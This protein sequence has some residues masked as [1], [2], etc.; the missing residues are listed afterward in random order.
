VAGTP[1][2]LTI[3][4]ALVDNVVEGYPSGSYA[5][6]GAGNAGGGAS[7]SNPTAND[8]MLV[9]AEVVMEVPVVWVVTDGFIRFKWRSWWYA[10]SNLW[11]D[12]D[13]L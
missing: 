10:F 7:D 5:R 4:N 6:G 9:V 8:R 3:N 13:L 2:Y 1:R 11:P 12:S